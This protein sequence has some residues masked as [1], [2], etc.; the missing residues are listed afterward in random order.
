MEKMPAEELQRI[1]RRRFAGKGDYRVR[2]WKVLVEFFSQWITPDGRVLDLGAGYCEFIN[3]I[4]AGVRYAMDLN[5]DT[6][7]HAGPGVL[8][9]EQDCSNPWDIQD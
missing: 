5:T 9:L 3:A 8:L 4:P 6:R 7:Q 1:Y 2:I